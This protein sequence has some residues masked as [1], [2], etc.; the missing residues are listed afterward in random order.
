MEFAEVVRRRRMVRDYDPDRPVPPDVR[1]RLLAHAIRAPSAGFSQG[2]AFLVLESDEERA[3][4]WAATT[5]SA[6]AHPPGADGW[7]TRMRRAPLLVVPM[8][9]KDA[10]LDRYAEADKG[11]TDRDESRWPVPY[12][13][14]DAGM[15]SL[16][17]LLTAVDE[18]LGACFFGVPAD[19]VTGLRAA[20][21]V[22]DQYRPVGCLSV[23]YPGDGDRRSPSL[24]RGRRGLDEV[25][26][27]GRW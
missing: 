20:F 25:V 21:G 5:D 26:H 4:F 18:G 22:P 16:L 3:R 24:R 7:L 15:A 1:E 19:K 8:S 27:R 14:V 13:D 9:N 10:Y 11:W 23:G 6:A 17:M 2:W 12:W